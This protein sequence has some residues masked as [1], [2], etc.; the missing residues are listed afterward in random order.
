MDDEWTCPACGHTCPVDEAMGELGGD[1][2]AA[3]VLSCPECHELD[4]GD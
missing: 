1:Q 2:D 4:W 3:G